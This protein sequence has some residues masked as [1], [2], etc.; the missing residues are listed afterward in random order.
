MILVTHSE[1]A[2][3]IADRVYTLHDGRLALREGVFPPSRW[4]EPGSAAFRCHERALFRALERCWRYLCVIPGRVS[5][6][7]LALA[8][9]VAVVV[10]M[11]CQCQ[12]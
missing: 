4:N 8:P 11:T 10:A 1:D 6:W 5:D 12:R 2:A 9:G 3:A 7:S